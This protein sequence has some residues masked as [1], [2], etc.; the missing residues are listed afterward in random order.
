[1]NFL[2]P[3]S[4][5]L[6]ACVAVPALLALYLLKLRRR[7]VR[8]GS[9]MLWQSAAEDTQ[10]NVPLRWLR[11]SWLLMLHLIILGLLV[12]ALGRPTLSRGPGARSRVVLLIDRSASMSCTDGPDGA[13]RLA[14]AQA[15]AADLADRATSSGSA[16]SV[17]SFAARAVVE[18][19]FTTSAGAARS[20]IEGIAP[21][22]QPGD[23][24][25]TLRL[26]DSLLVDQNEDRAEQRA[27]VCLLSDGS[28]A[29][30]EAPS[31]A[32]AAVSFVPVG[33][34][35]P[36][37]I[38]IVALAARRDYEDPGA[39]RV[40]ARV[41]STL[42]HDLDV[43]VALR[44]DDTVIE[45]RALHIARPPTPPAENAQAALS[46]PAE[47]VVTFQVRT[48]A[49]GAATVSID[50][51]DTLASDN[52]AS[53]VLPPARRA[54]ILLV[55]PAD[56]AARPTIVPPWLLEDALSQ[57]D[58]AS[59]RTIDDAEYERLTAA[60][61]MGG[62]DLFVF[63][64][65]RPKAPP[66]GA[67]LSFGAGLP[68]PGLDFRTPAAP[69]DG[70]YILAWDR[71]H[72]LLRDVALDQVFIVSGLERA[73][74]PPT[75]AAEARELATGPSGPLMLLANDGAHRRLVV[76]FDV[77]ASNWPLQVS[78][79]VFLAT[80]VDY[81]TLRGEESAGR[82][83]TTAEPVAVFAPPGVRSFD[84]R[85]ETLASATASPAVPALTDP[86]VVIPVTVG[87]DRSGDP[88]PVGLV[89]RAG[90]YRVTPPG[91]QPYVAVNLVNVTETECAANS[92]VR[93]GAAVVASDSSGDVPREI[94]LWFVLAAAA[95]L[96]VEWGVYA[97]QTR[98]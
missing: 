16:V 26:V 50:R 22:D 92:V 90:L 72:P 44:L 71:S 73:A 25:A 5:V 76:A 53:I 86:P 56:D 70:E 4:A 85:R 28:F 30:A 15:K 23:L 62:A 31:L 18:C 91:A 69:S 93:V 6:G 34:S 13:T 41:L 88:V 81:L 80:S 33:S 46:R 40:F 63:D 75:G 29:S 84:L 51:P 36:R 68:I 74:P 35:D 79:P 55:R 42:D 52:Q 7:P 38:G 19:G 54:S 77:A 48:P 11:A 12:T 67:S 14:I 17:V 94:W 9:T 83:F 37:N 89:E 1:M 66:P 98:A 58:A 10:A 21:T 39:V 96:A 49:G 65:V 82:A 20:A 24:G 2:D 57:L 97:A 43:P 59:F 95:L 60:G 78:F 61:A 45:R 32:G 27:T 3:M 64:R 47:A 8:V 87:P